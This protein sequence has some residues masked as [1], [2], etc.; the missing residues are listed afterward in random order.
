MC[1]GPSCGA[2][3]IQ[4]PVEYV[5]PKLVER[6]VP[7]K[8]AKPISHPNVPMASTSSAGRPVVVVSDS[9]D[10]DK[11]VPTFP[12]EPSPPPPD[13]S[14]RIVTIPTWVTELLRD[15]NPNGKDHFSK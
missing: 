9:S 1:L 12:P 5:R 3:G 10:S 14:E 8:R 15:G 13:P 6:I 7:V 2:P 4:N 11:E